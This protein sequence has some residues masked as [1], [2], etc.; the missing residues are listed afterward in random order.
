MATAIAEPRLSV[1]ATLQ[2]VPLVGFFARLVGPAALTAAGM[3]GAG[4]VAT[5]LLAGAWFG[6]DLLWVALY[7]VPMVVFALD[8][9]SR[10]GVL[11][12]GRGMFEM[13]RTDIGA[14]LAWAIF[15]PTVLV[16][17]IVNMSQMSAM[18][19]GS[20]GAA[21]LLPPANGQSTLGLAMVTVALTAVTVVSAV[22]GGYKRVEKIMTT[23]LVVI[24]VSFIVVAIKGLLDWRTWI[25]LGQ[26]LVPQVPAPVPVVGSGR[27][28]DAF[29]QI[30]AIAGQALPPAVFLSY[31][32][33]AANAGYKGTAAE[34]RGAF[35][36]TVQNL[37]VIW[38]LFSVVVIVAGATALHAVYTG[39][40][41]GYLGVSHYS[42]IE[43]IPVAGQVLGPAFPGALGFLAPR[44]FSIGLIAAAFTTL[45]SV[46]LTMTYFCLDMARMNWH[47]TADNRPFKL[48]FAVWI[49]IPAL[50][51]PFWQLPALLKAILAM[52]GNLLLAPVA[53]LVILYFVNQK[54]LG[55]FRANTG[56]NL[57]LC[58]T[59]AFA[60]VLV[61]NGLRGLL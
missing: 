43:S 59:A 27:T 37:G 40:G 56:R 13:I 60:L 23:L 29:T 49:A 21:G 34:I 30:M 16:N 8:S 57:V 19:E 52:V 41:P 61:I 53:V 42:Q 54:S 14:W 33:L 38:G 17:V 25:A 51:A 3:I 50:V 12:N 11:S 22:L 36:K 28:R 45:I 15:V 58:L 5:R 46:S 20:Y 32:Y 55:E 9:A 44:F 4:A 2:R 10:V 48:V 7:V 39:A 1:G 47:F 18:V 31:G 35:W 24:L 26:G 6:F